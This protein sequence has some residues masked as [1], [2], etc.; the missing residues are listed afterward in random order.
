M[1]ADLSGE[2]LNFGDKRLNL[3]AHML[4]NLLSTD[5]ALS[6]PK[7]ADDW[8]ALKALYRFMSNRKVTHHKILEPHFKQTALRCASVPIVLAVQDTTFL[9]FQNHPATEGMGPTH[10][11]NTDGWGMLVHSV[12]AVNGQT[13]APLGLL[14]QNVF[15][16]KGWYSEKETY[17]ERIKRPRESDKWFKGSKYVKERLPEP[18]R[19]L[20]VADREADIF[21]F[22]KET[23]E[24]GQGFVIRATRNRSTEKGYL[25]EE[26]KHAHLVGTEHFSVPHKGNRKVRIAKIELRSCRV[27][28]LPPKV[29]KHQGDVL[30]VNV[31]IIEEVEAPENVEP[32]YWILLTSEPVSDFNS[33][34]TVMGYYQA[35]WMIEEFHKGLKTGC[36]MEKRQLA[37]RSALEN[38][39][40][41]FSIITVQLLY[42]RYL[43]AQDNPSIDNGGLTSSQ[44]DILKSKF[45]KESQ[46]LDSKRIL[47][48]VARLG[49]FIG[50]K[51]DGHPGWQTLMHGMYELL[52]MDHGFH[53]AQK[54]MGKG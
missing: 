33:A 25:F 6:F 18:Q 48:L 46:I 31:L 1:V 12:F 9:N 19:I 49:G 54:L 52:L 8:G 27:R 24:S 37:C 51:S 2:G 29:I 15:V 14:H 26:I 22:L 23:I 30:S 32:M 17:C 13:K 11:R 3:R 10:N 47:F 4:V 50:R 43:A 38:A 21:F 16:R 45:P 39:L 7:M 44:I 28:L 36:Q 41:L 40:G 42:L 5:P 34:W 53:L 20:Q 35:R